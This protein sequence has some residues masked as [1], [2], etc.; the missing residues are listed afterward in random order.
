ME[1]KNII[2]A[3]AF[4]DCH[5]DRL[6]DR[7]ADILLDECLRVDRN[8]RFECQVSMSADKVTVDCRTTLA[9]GSL[10][11]LSKFVCSAVREAGYQAIYEVEIDI[12]DDNKAF[13]TLS[14]PAPNNGKNCSGNMCVGHCT[15]L[16]SGDI[17]ADK[18]VAAR[19]YAT[20]E[21][22]AFLPLPTVLAHRIM[23]CFSMARRQ[24]VI[25]GLLPGSSVT[26]FAH[27]EDEEPLH[28]DTVTL[29]ASCEENA[30]Q[31]E[32]RRQLR[33]LVIDP[34]LS[35]LAVVE[36]K[37]I[38]INITSRRARAGLPSGQGGRRSDESAVCGEIGSQNGK[39]GRHVSRSGP[40]MARY[41]A[42]NI[43]AAGLA[44]ECTVCASY[45]QGSSRPDISV[46]MHGTGEYPDAQLAESISDLFDFRP[47]AMF[48]V[49]RL[50][51]PV[52]ADNASSDLS[53]RDRMP[54]EQVN[55]IDE[56]RQ[57]CYEKEMEDEEY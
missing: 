1:A 18:T 10:P 8:A 15:T 46:D 19:G 35:G 33:R 36:D 13:S 20:A 53:V 4:S 28:I 9:S 22:S 34:A 5:P 17:P 3:K 30:D 41:A 57:L 39:D 48:I 44:D 31:S 45:R 26:V 23:L 2:T 11:D 7:I 49:L 6:C 24:S 51:R 21:T 29:G 40:L 32:V 37:D 43:V 56:L 25:P 55:M 47:A 12:K 14:Q 27:C 52:F 50:S 38:S 16:S 54:W 42:K